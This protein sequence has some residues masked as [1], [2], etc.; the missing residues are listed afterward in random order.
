MDNTKKVSLTQKIIACI[1][2]VFVIA[3]PLARLNPNFFPNTVVA[4]LLAF[5]LFATL[6]SVLLFWKYIERKTKQSSH[7]MLGLVHS[8]LAFALAF[9]FTKWGLLK[10]LHLHMTTSLGLMEMPMTMVTGEKQLSHFFGQSYP[11]VCTL[12]I[13]EILGAVFILFGKTRLLG[14]MILFV[15]TANIILID[16]LYNVHNPLLEAF[17][18]LAGVLYLAYQDKE[19]IINFFFSANKNLPKFNF[20]SS[21]LK[22]ALRLSAI[23]IPIILFAPQYRVQFRQGLT[24]KYNIEKMTINGKNKT[25]DQCSDTTFS[26][27]YFDLGDFFAFTNNN[28]KKKQIGHFTFDETKRTFETTWEYPKGIK[29]NFK[30]TVTNLDNKNRMKLTGIM[31]KDTFEIELE[32][33]EV[34]NFNKT[35]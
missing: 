29:D 28:F 7:S 18:L 24:G 13:L 1:L 35:Y 22:N 33:M 32:K 9:H 23:F 6:I 25:I 5:L 34:K 27:V 8:I 3:Y 15:M 17:T 11:M 31:A 20:R 26:K 30:G 10:I 14:I 4:R 12:G 21:I 19:K 2:T 16:I